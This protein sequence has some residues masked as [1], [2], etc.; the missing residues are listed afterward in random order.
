MNED[1]YTRISDEVHMC[2][3]VDD[4]NVEYVVSCNVLDNECKSCELILR[5]INL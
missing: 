4:V 2:S 5:F 1:F 3:S